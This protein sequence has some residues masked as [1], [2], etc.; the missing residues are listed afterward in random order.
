MGLK[1][2]AITLCVVSML[3]GYARRAEA[4]PTP[5]IQSLSYSSIQ[6]NS[7]VSGTT[8]DVTVDSTAGAGYACRWTSPALVQ[9]TATAS[10]QSATLM[11]C[12]LTLPAPEH[13]GAYTLE[14]TADGETSWSNAVP[15][16]YECEA[17]RYGSDCA[18]CTCRFADATLFLCDDGLSGTGTCIGCPAFV[19]PASCSADCNSFCS[20]GCD[21]SGC[22]QSTCNC[23]ACDLGLTGDQCDTSCDVNCSDTGGCDQSTAVCNGCDP[24]LYGDFCEYTC[25]AN[26]AGAGTCAQADGTCDSGCVAGYGG[27]NCAT[28]A[29]PVGGVG[30]YVLLA[31]L[32]GAAGAGARHVERAKR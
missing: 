10:L 25:S 31:L 2:P 6:A 32:L 16:V 24:G 8:V 19:F 26:C 22:A 18:R 12:E 21:T 9:T 27:A 11:S 15:F 4:Q 17:G 5:T 30:F 3:L 29:V 20:A 13:F 7:Y 1:G 23:F 14:V 28:P